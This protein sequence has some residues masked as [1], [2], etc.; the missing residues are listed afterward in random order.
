LG[1]TLISERRPVLFY[2]TLEILIHNT[3]QEA[4]S[5]RCELFGRVGE[6]ALDATEL[7]DTFRI[8]I[9]GLDRYAALV[10][11]VCKGL[12]KVVPWHLA[13]AGNPALVFAGVDVAKQGTSLTH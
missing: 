10:V 4:Q 5:F 13:A 7:G 9:K 2:V 8:G 12:E 11:D 3:L 1:K 6:F